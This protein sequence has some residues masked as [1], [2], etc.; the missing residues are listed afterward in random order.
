M[1][2]VKIALACPGRA[3]LP[4]GGCRPD[5]QAELSSDFRCRIARFARIP[6]ARF[7]Q[8]EVIPEIVHLFPQPGKLS[9]QSNSRHC[10]ADLLRSVNHK[11]SFDV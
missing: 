4:P 2:A 10:P 7:E 11:V 3:P 9:H 5:L 6:G 8:I 1:I